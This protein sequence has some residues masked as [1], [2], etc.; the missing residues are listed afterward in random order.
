VVIVPTHDHA[1]TLDIA[2]MSVLD[3]TVRSL[4]V[5]VIGDGVGND[6][7]SVLRPFLSDGRVRFIDR[8]K[9]PSRAEETRHGAIEGSRARFVAYLG[10][11]DL[12]LADHL[13]TM[14]ALLEQADF[15]HPSPLMVLPDGTLSAHPIDLGRPE[16]RRWQLRPENNAISPTGVVHRRDAYMRLAQGWCAPPPGRWSDH[17]M[18]EQW[19]GDPSCRFVT[20]RR[21]TALKL[22][23][24]ERATM[25]PQERRA[26]LADWRARSGGPGFEA[27]L[28]RLASDAWRRWAIQARLDLSDLEAR[29]LEHDAEI[30][31]HRADRDEALGRGGAGHS[32]SSG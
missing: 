2:L 23:S 26:E 28:T 18:W 25:S 4:E 7:R 5:V 19:F 9:S 13:E 30:E 14:V 16:W 6:T 15:A 8:P 11:D 22:P 10:D 1:S 17:Y 20:G 27:E 24:W 31:A 32:A 29:L 3:Q 21:L 12:M